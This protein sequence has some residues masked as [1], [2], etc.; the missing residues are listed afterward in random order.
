MPTKEKIDFLYLMIEKLTTLIA[1][2][3]ESG[4][5]DSRLEEFIKTK[6]GFDIANLDLKYRNSGDLLKGK[7][8]SGKEFKYVDMNDDLDI[9]NEV[10]KWL[11]I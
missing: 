10:K 11:K 8:Q 2:A 6:S 9:I 7:I 5:A 4:I 3:D 1:T